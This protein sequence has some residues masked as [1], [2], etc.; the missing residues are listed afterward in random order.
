LGSQKL[1]TAEDAEHAEEQIDG[2]LK[3]TGC[4]NQNGVRASR[5]SL[6]AESAEHAEEQEGMGPKAETAKN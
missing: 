5:K 3:A 1:L 2:V 4:E 6:T